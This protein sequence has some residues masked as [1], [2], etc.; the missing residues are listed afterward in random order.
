METFSFSPPI[1]FVEEGNWLLAVISFEA[2]NSVFNITNENNS[3]S[4]V[5]PGHRNSK[6]AEKTI[7]ELNIL[8]ERRSHNDIELHVEQ[9]R[10]TGEF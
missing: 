6:S 1:I 7:N 3:F 10:K 9:V 5:I 2:T 4:F 8:L